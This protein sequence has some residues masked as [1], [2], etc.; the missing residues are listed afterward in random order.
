[1]PLSDPLT[2]SQ[3]GATY[4]SHP[5]VFVNAAALLMHRWAMPEQSGRR[6]AR[7]SVGQSVVVLPFRSRE[8]KIPVPPSKGTSRNWRARAIS[9]K[10]KLS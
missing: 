4:G 6:R 8:N 2:D 10:P 9:R 3:L 5:E 1:M 7:K